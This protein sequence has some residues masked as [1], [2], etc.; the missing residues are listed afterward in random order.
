MMKL[1][2]AEFDRIVRE[3]L[4]EV[5]AFTNEKQNK[6]IVFE[7]LDRFENNHHFNLQFEVMTHYYQLTGLTCDG[8]VATVKKLLDKIV[9]IQ[10]IDIN[11]TRNEATITMTQ[12]ISTE[13]LRDALKSHPKYTITDKVE[14]NVPPQY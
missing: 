12:H 4:N 13:A 10:S 6:A 14:V 2:D 7:R 8:C 5:R 11:E 9:G 1:T 3:K